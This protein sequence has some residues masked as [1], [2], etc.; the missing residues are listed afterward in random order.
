MVSSELVGYEFLKF[1]L[2]LWQAS[3]EVATTDAGETSGT[4]NLRPW[5]NSPEDTMYID[6]SRENLNQTL[7]QF[8]PKGRINTG[9]LKRVETDEQLE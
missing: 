3:S 2:H 4:H 8:T 9:R 6:A 1:H 7:K 5:P